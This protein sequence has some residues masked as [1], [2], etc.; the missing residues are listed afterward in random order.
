MALGNLE[1][2]QN[3]IYSLFSNL[4]EKFFAADKLTDELLSLTNL[5]DDLIWICSKQKELL[6][7]N[8]SFLTLFNINDNLTNISS[9]F[10][11]RL[12]SFFLHK[13][14]EDSFLLSIN[15][16]VYVLSVISKAFGNDDNP[17]YI[18]Y[19]AYCEAGENDKDDIIKNFEAL[20]EISNNA[21][22]IVDQ[23]GI[24]LNVND[25]FCKLVKKEKEELI[26]Q[27]YDVIYKTP[28]ESPFNFIAD[29]KPRFES[30]ITLWTG[31][32]FIFEIISTTITYK[33]QRQAVLSIFR[34]ITHLRQTEEK[35]EKVER[36]FTET[37]EMIPQIFFEA[38]KKGYLT[39]VNSYAY[40][41]FG[42]T[43][44]VLEKH[45]NILDFVA[46]ESQEKAI[47]NFALRLQ[48]NQISQNEYTFITPSGKIIPALV[49]TSPIIRDNQIEGLRG[50]I[51]DI[52]ERK[53][54]EEISKK[55]EYLY[56]TIVNTS[57]DG[58]SLMSINGQIIFANDKKA[59]LFGYNNAEELIG[60]NA[61]DLVSDE[62]SSLLN[63]SYFKLLK[64][65]KV[66]NI[67]LKL[68]RKDGTTFYGE[69][70][71]QLILDNNNKPANIMDVVTD[72]TEKLMIEE[73]RRL[74]EIRTETLLKVYQM[75]NIEVQKI[76]EYILN[77]AVNQ[78]SS[79]AGYL[80][81][82]DENE[83]IDKFYIHH[84]NQTK[85]I[86]NKLEQYQIDYSELP[87]WL[88]PLKFKDI[89]IYNNFSYIF[90]NQKK[91]PQCDLTIKRILAVPIFNNNKISI[92]AGLIN[93]K[94]YYSEI[95]SKQFNLIINSLNV[96]LEKLKNDHNLELFKKAI[97]QNPT[98]VLITD[99]KSFIKYAN[100]KFTEITGYHLNQ[101]IDKTTQELGLF[102]YTN[103][104]E[105]DKEAQNTLKQQDYWQGEIHF[106][107]ADGEYC[108]L[109]INI[110]AMKN[111]IGEITHYI[112]IAQ[113][114]TERKNI[115]KQLI[116]A[117]E[118]AERSDRLKSEFL[119]QMSHEIRTPINVILSFISLIKDE[120]NEYLDEDLTNSF[121]SINRAGNR[122][123]R[124]IDL[125]LNMSELQTGTY[126]Y[127]PENINLDEDILQPLINE[128][129]YIAKSKGLTL[130]YENL[131]SLPIVYGDNYSIYQIFANLIDNAIKFTREGSVKIKLNYENGCLACSV[132][133][134][135]IGISEE[136][137]PILFTPFSQEQQG[138]TRS[139]EGNGLGLALVKKYCEL[140]N[141]QISC[142]SKKDEGSCFKVC[143]KINS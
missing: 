126:D 133:D 115:D 24:I 34:N 139:F 70:R 113:D 84:Q 136:Y 56:K 75:E 12:N 51:I 94:S 15:S 98:I 36:K 138:Y 112:G 53:K 20:W 33:N 117:K 76:S 60:L 41:L 111:K 22:R 62:S 58:I 78:T 130:E 132:I 140:N 57:P 71:A 86:D 120:L 134:T 1:A 31:E 122:L 8:K 79:E 37:A 52:T 81:F 55:N 7:A 128:H 100:K 88:F 18:F 66:E 91:L 38:D 103:K 19:S 68:K 29:F 109:L 2:K 61:F 95:D 108:W 44:N 110:S 125:L 92:I 102:P 96:A 65:Y 90:H 83:K 25:N 10:E 32:N 26:G 46:P 131:V 123:I 35:L 49:Y 124:T 119:A 11:D 106:K 59:K 143:F 9:I 17:I 142:N 82:F 127:H 43:E 48:N 137:L 118:I 97:E 27:Y 101:V 69:F 129:S 85:I 135:G 39:Y 77:G 21:L 80:I 50:I 14:Y 47:K 40:K 42:V 54:L 64:F 114:I 72:V 89:V 16:K 116:E 99:N 3:E 23:D 28:I 4:V 45:F 74:N 5:L 105:T 13:E 73:E 63:E 121:A 93:K 141:A 6:F 67:I 107:K 87:L 30:S 104:S